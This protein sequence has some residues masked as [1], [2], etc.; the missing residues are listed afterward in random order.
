MNSD[1]LW[2]GFCLLKDQILHCSWS[3]QEPARAVQKE[4]SSPVAVRIS[5]TASY[6]SLLQ[7]MQCLLAVREREQGARPAAQCSTVVGHTAQRQW[8][9]LEA[10]SLQ[11][12]GF[13][14]R[15]EKGGRWSYPA[16]LVSLLL[17]ESTGS[18]RSLNFDYKGVGASFGVSTSQSLGV[19]VWAGRCCS[20]CSRQPITAGCNY[21]LQLQRKLLAVGSVQCLA[22]DPLLLRIQWRWRK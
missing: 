18:L 20:R 4:A 15:R 8:T 12:N 9:W 11:T 7:H 10:S 5:S 13:R 16:F 2:Q 21:K 19:T 3:S 14:G 6:C 17:Q 1:D 22:A